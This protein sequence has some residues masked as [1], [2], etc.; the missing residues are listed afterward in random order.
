MTLVDFLHFYFLWDHLLLLSCLL[1]CGA[2][3]MGVG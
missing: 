2:R 3:G 1:A